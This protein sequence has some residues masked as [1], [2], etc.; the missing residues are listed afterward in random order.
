MAPASAESS[1]ALRFGVTYC[2]SSAN[3]RARNPT[4]FFANDRVATLCGELVR[5]VRLFSLPSGRPWP[6]VRVMAIAYFATLCQAQPAALS[7]TGYRLLARM[8][9]LRN[10]MRANGGRH[11]LRCPSNDG[12]TTCRVRRSS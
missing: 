10:V 4:G 6:E 7:R 1:R 3:L 11:R 8:H 9:M 2:E 5:R 12:R